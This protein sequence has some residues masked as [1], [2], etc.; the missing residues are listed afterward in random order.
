MGPT[1]KYRKTIT[2]KTGKRLRY[3]KMERSNEQEN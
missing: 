1:E 3:R 2:K